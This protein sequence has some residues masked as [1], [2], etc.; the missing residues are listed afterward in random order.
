[1]PAASRTTAR[2][3][4]PGACADGLPWVPRE[5]AAAVTEA[6]HT[7]DGFRLILLYCYRM[8]GIIDYEI[9]E[10]NRLATCPRPGHGVDDHP[11]LSFG[12]SQGGRLWRCMSEGV[13]GDGLQLLADTGG[14]DRR[15]FRRS[16]LAAGDALGIPRPGAPGSRD[17]VAAW[18]RIERRAIAERHGRPQVR[19]M[20]EPA[21]DAAFGAAFDVF[22]GVAPAGEQRAL[23]YLIRERGIPSWA[24][25]R[26]ARCLVLDAAELAA[27]SVVL[28]HGPHAA[29]C[30]AAGILHRDRDGQ[31]RLIWRDDTLL[32]FHVGADLSSM[33]YC[34]GRR[35]DPATKGQRYRMPH[36]DGATLPPSIAPLS[37][38]VDV[39]DCYAADGSTRS[40]TRPLAYRSRPVLFGLPQAAEASTTNR[41]LVLEGA[42]KAM[43]ATAMG[44]Q[45][46]ATCG[47]LGWDGA[48]DHAHRAA[49]S[50]GV[51]IGDLAHLVDAEILVVPDHDEDLAVRARMHAAAETL[52]EALRL[53]HGL[54]AAVRPLAD[55]V[56][57]AA[58]G[59]QPDGSWSKDADDALRILGPAPA[60]EF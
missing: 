24:V 46:V 29:A 28:A 8:A 60:S 54:N 12:G 21:Q 18:H 11:S 22:S 16:V 31:S 2:S 57:H 44:H 53:G 37:E 32:M 39:V 51:A 47:M 41:L 23:D 4:Q 55:I 35:L 34:S 43:A 7:P 59:R 1:M 27:A 49:S 15:D 40:L 38:T 13:G 48:T 42:I 56:G 52:A 9:D 30:E 17:P 5:Y 36:G 26:S 20:P 10:H 6:A 50:L 25:E 33:R 14:W 19:T 3:P 45:A 58:V